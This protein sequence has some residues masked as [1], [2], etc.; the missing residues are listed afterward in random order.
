MFPVMR[1]EVNMSSGDG[2][3]SFSRSQLDYLHDCD[4]VEYMASF[5]YAGPTPFT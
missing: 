5:M 4:E 1:F 3:I 2:A